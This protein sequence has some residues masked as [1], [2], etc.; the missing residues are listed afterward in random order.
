[1]IIRRILEDLLFIEQQDHAALSAAIMAEWR[2]GGLP[3]HPHR[4]A[5]LLAT[6]EHDSGWRE[7]DAMT[8]VG[9]AGE[10]LD[11]L[12]VPPTVKQRIW[13]RAVARV[14][15][16]DPYAGA[17]VAQHA[18]SLHGQQQ[19]E[20][21]WRPFLRQI[22]QIQ[23]DLLARCAP[24]AAGSIADDYRFVQ[25]GDQ[26]SLV[27]CHGSTAS[28]ARPGGCVLLEHAVL[29]VTPDPFEG[30]RIPLRVPARRLPF[31]TFGSE[32]ELR[33]ALDAAPVENVQ[34]EAQGN[35]QQVAGKV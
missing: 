7:E 17:L 10:P 23:G 26:L 9:E 6:R 27:F 25:A 35:G 13:P 3:D 12:S 8:H 2:L 29:I 32:R 19:T 30:R 24:G 5:I 16:L 21:A 14:A 15:A 34:G 22:E 11:F 33:A 20:P 28:F 1:M 31:R 18:L 4:A